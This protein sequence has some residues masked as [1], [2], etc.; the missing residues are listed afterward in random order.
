[1]CTYRSVY[2]RFSSDKQDAYEVGVKTAGKFLE[3]VRNR[4]GFNYRIFLAENFILIAT[5][6]RSNVE[7]AINNLSETINPENE[8]YSYIFQ[9]AIIFGTFLL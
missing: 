8:V 5:K 1:M 9:F 2:I 7:Q 3:E 4:P 6:N